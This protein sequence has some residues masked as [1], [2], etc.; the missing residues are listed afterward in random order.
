MEKQKG[1]FVQKIKAWAWNNLLVILYFISAVL[2]EVTAVFAVE[3]TPFLTRPFLSLGVLSFV[4]GIILLVKNNYARTIICVLMLLL[5]MFLD[6]AFDVVFTL[7]DQYFDFGMFNLRNDA[8]AILENIPV[9]FVIFYVGLIFILILSVYGFR[10][11]YRVRRVKEPKHTAFFYVGL[12]LAGIATLFLSFFTYF[13]LEAKNKYDEMVEGRSKTAYSS[14]GII[15]NLLGETGKVLFQKTTPVNGNDIDEFIYR[16]PAEKTPYFGVAKDKNVLVILAE[17]LEWYTFLRGNTDYSGSLKEEYPHALNISQ[18]DLNTLYPNLTALYD[19]S[20]VMTN[21]HGREKT[22]IAETLSIMGSYPTDAYVNYD[23][24]A[25]T[26]PQTLPNLLKEVTDGNIYLRSFHNGFKS[27]YNREVAHAAFGFEKVDGLA[28]PVDMNDMEEM[29]NLLEEE[30]NPEIF[31]DYMDEGERN[32]DSEMVETAKHLMFPTD[33]RFCTYITTL[34]MHGMYYDRVNMRK[35]NNTKL[36]RQLTLLEQ[37]KPVDTEAEDFINA[38]QLYYYM[39]TGLEFDYM[40]GCIKADLEE[41]GLL[42][43]TLIALYADHNAYYQGMSGYVKEIAD[44]KSEN[45][46]TDLYNVPFMI[47]DKDLAAAVPSNERIVDKFTCTADIVPTLLDLLGIRYF[48]N[49][50]YGNSVFSEAQSVLYSRAYDIFI[51][52]GIVR[53][54]VNGE[55]YLYEGETERGEKVKDTVKDFEAEGKKL[56]E[57]IEYIDYIFRQDHFGEIT[58]NQRF[59]EEMKKINS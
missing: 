52:D 10:R 41:K 46:F 5:Q 24:S 19:E 11:S 27:F 36:A 17:S 45:K 53:R 13:P 20:V 15:G 49:L 31:H 39:T 44:Y 22:D 38:E 16:T 50:Y 12:S 35:E 43:K 18:E 8:F 7:T 55:L 40:L 25:N 29:S 37:Y 2:L 54:S 34:T 30:G 42:D 48:E 58:N 23:Y 47:W 9:S 57:K 59:K 4:C 26:M 56:V 33:Q 3:G 28:C 51:G 1:K 6:L 21:F 32:L 14:Y